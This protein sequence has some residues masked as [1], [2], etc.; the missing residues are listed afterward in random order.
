[1]LNS[2][3]KD[4]D[5]EPQNEHIEQILIIPQNASIAVGEQL[6]FSTVGITTDGDT[7]PTSGMGL[8]W[9]WWST[10]PYVF[11]I[12]NDGTATGQNPGEAFCIL[13][14]TESTSR[15]KFSGRD[16]AIVLIF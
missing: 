14:F 16:T 6:E 3:D 15:L 5:T 9:N 13:D 8:E 2:C 1:M 7:L 11:T 10:D 4:E 12:D